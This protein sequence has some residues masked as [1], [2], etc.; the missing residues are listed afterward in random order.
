[1][2]KKVAVLGSGSW[3]TALAHQLRIS[4]LDVWLWGIEEDVLESI[5]TKQVNP[6]YFP[7]N[8][9]AAGINCELSIEK[10]V[11]GAELVVVAVPSSVIREVASSLK[12]LNPETKKFVIV[13][14]G[15]EQGSLALLSDV[16]AEE[17]GNADNIAVLSGP[18]FAKEVLEEKP[19]AVTVAASSIKIADEVAN[20]FHYGAFRV[21]TSDD[22]VGVQLGGAVKNIIALAT[23]IIDGKKMGLNARAALLTR[24]LVEISR[25]VVKM[26]GREETVFGLSGLGDLILTST[27]DL[28]RNRK[29]G[30]A[31]GRGDSLEKIL[32]DIGQV[33]EGVVTAPKILALAKKL[34]IEMP[35]TEEIVS[36]LEGKHSVDIAL[37]NLLSREGKI[38]IG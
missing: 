27:G 2:G 14:K 37:K 34:E 24:G 23:G 17:L 32:K 28:S 6:T 12:K 20:Y 11:A 8:K 15:L 38:E 33:A 3:G 31:L 36:V 9:I 13:A 22:L 35:I 7:D 26:G 16:L 25:L 21:Y 10:A 4:G 18:S 19:T 29:V 1:M 30:L 5:A